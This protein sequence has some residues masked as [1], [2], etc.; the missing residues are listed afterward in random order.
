MLP[1]LVQKGFKTAEIFNKIWILEPQNQ[2]PNSW[3]TNVGQKLPYLMALILPNVQLQ[4]NM[5]N[6]RS[7]ETW[8]LLIKGNWK[9]T[10]NLC[11]CLRI[12]YEYVPRQFDMFFY[13]INF[14]F[15]QLL[16]ANQPG[17][18]GPYI[19]HIFLGSVKYQVYAEK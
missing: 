6:I 7:S 18:T 2:R 15:C 3:K 16:S 14:L 5:K 12:E 8:V 1:I 9:T 13:L 10:S 11:T 4:K 17:L 19:F